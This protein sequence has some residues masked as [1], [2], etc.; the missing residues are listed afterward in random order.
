[1]KIVHV[2]GIVSPDGSY[3][4]PARVALDQTRALLD[5]G[6]DVTLVAGAIGFGKLPPKNFDGVPVHLFPAHRLVPRSGFAGLVAPG[7]TRWLANRLRRDVD[8]LHVH[9]A[10]DLITLPAAAQGALARKRLVVQPHGMIERSQNPFAGPLDSLAT[11]RVLRYAEKVF[12]LT[13]EEKRELSMVAGRPLP[14]TQL[15]NG[16]ASREIVVSEPQPR[17]EV[18]FLARMHSRKRP[19][20]F[21]QMA[22]KLHKLYPDVNFRLVGPDEG[23]GNLVDAAIAKAAMGDR[24]RWEGP[25]EPAATS[26]RFA[27]SSIYVL[28]A[29]NEP[30]GMTIL[31]AMT[32][33]KP[34]VVTETC[35]IAGRISNA[36]AGIIVNGDV[37]SMATAVAALLSD[38]TLR[39]SL[40]K[41]A[42]ALAGDFGMSPV[43]KTL[44]DAYTETVA[45]PPNEFK[46]L[47]D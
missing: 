26:R 39:E 6:Y 10:R 9:L 11:K 29:V 17:L 31:E 41:N 40:G 47:N 27:Q 37:D 25:L 16:I 34:V 15:S 43:V 8:L 12:H 36:N 2:L 33:G 4:G 3:G 20:A 46:D 44:A 1:M 42:R 32:Q 24:L 45:I 23:E 13:N 35:G 19:V 14:F 5:A 7:L 22:E 21:V 30:F 38:S 18:L 28:P